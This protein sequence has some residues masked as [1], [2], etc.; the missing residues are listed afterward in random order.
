MIIQ[1]KGKFKNLANLAL[2]KFGNL[3][4]IS[5]KIWQL[6]PFFP[7]ESQCKMCT[8]FFSF[9]FSLFPPKWQNS[10]WNKIARSM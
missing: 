3:K 7:K 6:W 1:K 2:S 5:L 4:K 9:S 10:I 8:A